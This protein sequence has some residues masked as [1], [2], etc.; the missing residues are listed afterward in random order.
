MKIISKINNKPKHLIIC[1][2]GRGQSEGHF[3]DYIDFWMPETLEF[4]LGIVEIHPGEEWYASPNGPQDQQKA[5]EGVKKATSELI[6]KIKEVSNLYSVPID[7][8]S[9]L[10]FSAGGVMAIQASTQLNNSEG[11]LSSVVCHSGA[12]FE[13]HELPHSKNNTAILLIHR[14]GD[15]CFSWEERYEPMKKALIDKNYNLTCLEIS[16]GDHRI[17]SLDIAIA[18]SFIKDHFCWG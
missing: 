10:G 9:L 1:L 5:V 18:D 2:P 14:T 13:P 15:D 7:Q 12:I 6:K 3:L 4:E 8:I 16:G 11:E 17:K